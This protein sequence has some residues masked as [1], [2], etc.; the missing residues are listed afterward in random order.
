MYINFVDLFMFI[1]ASNGQ[2]MN[3]RPWPGSYLDRSSA[4]SLMGVEPTLR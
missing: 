2:K 4:L 1:V 3:D